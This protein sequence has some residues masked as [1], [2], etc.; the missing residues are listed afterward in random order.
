MK[1]LQNESDMPILLTPNGA[2]D[3]VFYTSGSSEQNHV[4]ELPIGNYSIT[5]GNYSM[6]PCSQIS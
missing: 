1:G 4:F 3:T 2:K 6:D 5:I